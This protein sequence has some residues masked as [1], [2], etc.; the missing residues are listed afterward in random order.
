MEDRHPVTFPHKGSL[1]CIMVKRGNVCKA[2][3]TVAWNI[4]GLL[5]ITIIAVLCG[6]DGMSWYQPAYVV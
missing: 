5:L 2:L 3:S 6:D 1:L 4:K